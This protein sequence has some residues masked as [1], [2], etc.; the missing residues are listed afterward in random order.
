M[1]EKEKK[2]ATSLSLFKRLLLKS[3]WSAIK[4]TTKD[5]VHAYLKVVAATTG[6]TTEEG[7]CFTGDIRFQTRLIVFIIILV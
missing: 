3:H 1:S 6:S 4:S 2:T 7:D 5:S